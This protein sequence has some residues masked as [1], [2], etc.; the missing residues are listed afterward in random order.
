MPLA[1]AMITHEAVATG[2]GRSIQPVDRAAL[3]DPLFRDGAQRPGDSIRRD[4][5]SFPGDEPCH[6]HF[7]TGSPARLW[8]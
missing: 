3:R 8:R 4:A 2:F 1:A 5:R 7:V 6:A